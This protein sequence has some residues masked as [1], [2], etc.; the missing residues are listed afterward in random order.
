MG[1]REGQGGSLWNMDAPRVGSVVKELVE[2][3]EEAG[4]WM[5]L[6]EKEMEKVV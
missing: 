6:G 4:R 5:S 2:V 3:A 1:R